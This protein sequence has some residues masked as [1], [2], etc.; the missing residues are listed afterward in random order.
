MELKRQI[1]YENAQEKQLAVDKK[2][3]LGELYRVQIE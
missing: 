1:E 3:A 2:R